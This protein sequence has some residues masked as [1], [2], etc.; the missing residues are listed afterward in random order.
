MSVNN[1]RRNVAYGLSDALLNVPAPDI[2]SK[3]APTTADM[4]PIGQI[5]VNT[6]TNIAYILTSIVSNSANWLQ[7]AGNAGSFSSLTVT[8]GPTSLTGSFTVIAGTN[9]AHIADD[10]ADHATTLG[11][12]T[13]AS[14]TTIQ[15]GTSGIS[16]SA[17][18]N[19]AVVTALASVASPVSTAVINKRVGQATY[20]G[21]TTASTANQIFTITNS[22]VTATSA[23]L[24]T[25][26]NG[27]AND[28]R[29][30]MQQLL[31]SA[32]TIEVVTINNGTQALNGNVTIAFWVLN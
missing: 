3:R 21:F 1:Q 22:F 14:L 13:G 20:T 32:N 5:W 15:G 6:A 29:M 25:V 17:A 26:S 18:G 23:I 27:G 7:I 30:E 8:P 31:P 11:S 12:V 19:V 16:L 4:A 24:L 2:I 28:A 10:A 9:A